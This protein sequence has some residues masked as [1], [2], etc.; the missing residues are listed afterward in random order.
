MI[1]FARSCRPPHSKQPG[2][3]AG[4]LNKSALRSLVVQAAELLNLCEICV[5]SRVR[6][7]LAADL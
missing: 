4:F 2:W 7:Q 6:D 5:I 1:A 3:H